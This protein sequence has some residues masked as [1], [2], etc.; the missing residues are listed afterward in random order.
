MLPPPGGG[1]S[2]TSS[3]PAV[4]RKLPGATAPLGD[5]GVPVRCWQ[6]EQ[7]HQPAPVER[8]G[9]L[10]LDRAAGASTG[11]HGAHGS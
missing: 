6:R 2:V 4:S 3:S 9:D 5:A 10:E 8:L 11:E 1:H 7:W